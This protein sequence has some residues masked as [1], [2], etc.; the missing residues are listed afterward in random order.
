MNNTISYWINLSNNLLPWIVCG[1]IV[2]FLVAVMILLLLD[3]LDFRRLL[4]QPMVFIE[5]T[6]PAN[7]DKDIKATQRFF[8]GLHGLND[9][10]LFIAKL[11]RRK[12]L[13]SLEIVSTRENGIRY[14]LSAPESKL[15]TFEQTVAS[16]MPD[17]R[18]K[19]VADY[20]PAR[21]HLS[22][23]RVIEIKQM[24]H[25]AYP[26]QLQGDQAEHDPVSYLTG[27]M[28]KQSKDE[29]MA[30]EIIVSPSNVREAGVIASR[31]LHNEELVYQLG[32]RKNSI[33]GNIFSILGS[34]LFSILDAIGTA[35]SGIPS[36]SSSQGSQA[37]HRHQVA[38][39]EKPARVLGKF[40]Q[41]LAESVHDK[42]RQPLF[43]VT[44]RAV[45][46]ASSN[47]RQKQRVEGLRDWLALFT[48]PKYQK[49]K[50]RINFLSIIK[51]PYWLFMFTYR[52]PPLFSRSMLLLSASEIAELYHFP[53]SKTAKTEN[54]IKSH[55]KQ[56]PAPVSLKNGSKLDVLLG[57]NHYHGE[58]TPIGLTVEERERHV[59]IVGGTG[60]GKTTLMKYSVI[61]DIKNGKGVAVI[62]PHGDLAQEILSHIPKERIN[63]VIYFNPA[64]TA[65]PIGLNL[66][67]LPKELEGDALLD[68]KDFI[69]ETVVSIMRKTFSD[70]GSGG[71]RIEYVLR[72]AVLTALT[73]PD[74][75][76]FT[77]YDLLTNV[78]FRTPIVNKLEQEWLRNF[79]KNE[80]G[81]AGDYQAVKM[82]GG[83]TAKIGRYHASVSAERILSQ[84]K[85]TINFDEIL[86]GK[87]LICNLA[88]GLVGEDTSE[89][90]GISILAQLQLASF[91]RIKQ[92]R[93][94]RKPFYTYV[95]EFQNFATTSFVELLSEARKYKLFMTMA[96]QTVSQQDDQKMVNI[97]L[98]NAGTIITF[99]TNSPSDEKQILPLFSPYVQTGEIANLPAYNFYAKLSGGLV[100]QEP[101]SGMTVVMKEQNEGTN[102]DDILAA[103]RANYAKRYVTPKIT[104]SNTLNT[105]R[106]S[107]VKTAATSGVPADE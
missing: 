8:T 88:K 72:N 76:L 32:K 60:N 67:E 17:I 56:L 77:I 100:P 89:V 31:M 30:I 92:Q 53:H 5:L 54:V 44:I 48:V 84:P 15:A 105:K 6:P 34:I 10:R 102:A 22:R 96:E 43:R 47:E 66:L 70:D 69:A 55:S 106:A 7:T 26:L 46:V 11:L 71:H 1:S 39:K 4:K 33:V 13:F 65:Y 95:D 78:K 83:V 97:L 57:E 23:S 90:L 49:L 81:Q 40:E 59:F 74:A 80:I 36:K 104:K 87:I 20:L 99:K 52:M 101:V 19:Q 27:V 82:M 85:S 14:I 91:R 2:I 68:A 37:S 38:M 93:S 64:D 94:D 63:D 58:A 61:Q 107:P 12:E 35:T 42:L 18:Y 79:W 103:S 25:F 16:Y 98:A 21:E 75:T 50:P 86:D 3:I 24:G 28:T 73:V 9:S 45:I 29:I 51:Q 41:Q 62:D